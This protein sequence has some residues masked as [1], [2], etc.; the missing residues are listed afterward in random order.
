MPTTAMQA[1]SAQ[2]SVLALHGPLP[3]SM[4]QAS[5]APQLEGNAQQLESEVEP[6][7]QD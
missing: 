3:V 2:Q 4:Q 6:S 1:M 7:V 5:P